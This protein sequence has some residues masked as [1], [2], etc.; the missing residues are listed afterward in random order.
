MYVG[1]RV[2]V[3]HII[4]IQKHHDI[5][6]LL[7]AGVGIAS[8]LRIDERARLSLKQGFGCTIPASSYQEL[9]LTIARYHKRNG[10]KEG[11]W[12]AIIAYAWRLTRIES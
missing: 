11:T 2:L 12:E 3:S 4:F 5:I 9:K 1:H 8:H 7:E 6:C 10:A